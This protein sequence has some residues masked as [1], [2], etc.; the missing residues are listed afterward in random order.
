VLSPR[1][2]AFAAVVASATPARAEVGWSGAVRLGVGGALTGPRAGQGNIDLGV[3]LDVMARRGPYDTSWGGGA[4]FDAR[5]LGF[6]RHDFVFGGGVVTPDFYNLFAAGLRVGAGYRWRSDFDNG[7]VVATTFTFG[8]RLP[9]KAHEEVILGVYADARV[10]VAGG[11]P[12]E[13]TT[14]LEIDPAG[15][16]AGLYEKVHWEPPR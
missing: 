9:I 10:L 8:V 14:G 3:R 15:I 12:T 4:Y 2:L 1:A 11:A 5:T 7:A 6:T 13:L 16:V